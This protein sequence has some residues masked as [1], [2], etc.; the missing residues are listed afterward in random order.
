MVG[1]VGTLVGGERGSGGGGGGVAGG[2]YGESSGCEKRPQCLCEG[3]IEVFFVK[4][5]GKVGSGVGAAVGWI[6]DDEVV[7]EGGREPWLGL[8][9]GGEAGDGT[10]E[11]GCRGLE[12]WVAAW[13]HGVRFDCND[14]EGEWGMGVRTS[15]CDGKIV[16]VRYLL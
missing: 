1:G 9:I 11:Q 14:A 16:R 5:V 4:V 2:N 15:N 7:V 6:E 13:G 12:N 3:Q 8:R 10:Q